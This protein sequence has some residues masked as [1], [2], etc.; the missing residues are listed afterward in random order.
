MAERLAAV[1]AAAVDEALDEATVE[2][3]DVTELEASSLYNDMRLPAPQNVDLSP[4][5]RKLHAPEVVSSL[6]SPLSPFE[7]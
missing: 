5:Q 6:L 4:G 1:L 7:Q 3:P 2:V